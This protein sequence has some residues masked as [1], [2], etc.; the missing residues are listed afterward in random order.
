M[1]P[2][3][4][5]GSSKS[6]VSPTRSLCL[7]YHIWMKKRDKKMWKKDHEVVMEELVPKK[8]GRDAMI[9]KKKEKASYS[10]AKKTEDVEL[11]DRDLFGGSDFQRRVA[12][13][14]N[15]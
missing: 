1:K 12:A 2:K 14:R 8:T 7:H 15:R 13:E 5:F 11:N 10:K 9:D 3:A 6:A 4:T